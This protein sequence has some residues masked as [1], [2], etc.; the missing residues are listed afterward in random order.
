MSRQT[1][2]IE[3]APEPR[4]WRWQSLAWLVPGLV[5]LALGAWQVGLRLQTLAGEREAA[6]SQLQASKSAA[7]RL[8]AAVDPQAEAR[9]A[10]TDRLTQRLSRPWSSLL[11]IFESAD[12]QKVAVLAVQPTLQTGIVQ[13]VIEAA[14][15]DDMVDY[16]QAL[17]RDQ[18]LSAVGLV[19][20]ERLDKIPGSPVRAQITAHWSAK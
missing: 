3:F 2:H 7:A 8:A 11:E 4:A 14:S 10:A 12:T 5:L 19:S 17:Q 13:V 15:L 1:F 6:D 18:R 20:H 9:N 16:F